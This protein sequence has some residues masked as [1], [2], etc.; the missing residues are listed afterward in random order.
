MLINVIEI[1]MLILCINSLHE[2]HVLQYRNDD[3]AHI[4]GCVEKLR[5]SSLD[6]YDTRICLKILKT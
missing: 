1:S 5:I 2:E 3:Y 4:S 6:R